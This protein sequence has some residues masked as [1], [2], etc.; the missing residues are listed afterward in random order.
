MVVLDMFQNI[1]AHDRCERSRW[2]WQRLS[3]SAHGDTFCK[4][5]GGDDGASLVDE[6]L[7][8]SPRCDV[9]AQP[10]RYRSPLEGQRH[11]PLALHGT[12][13]GTDFVPEQVARTDERPEAQPPP[14]ANGA[15]DGL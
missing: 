14:R 8:A 2:K 3:V 1:A 9:Q 11:Q 10:G 13:A 4:Q 7:Q 12:T 5:V 15:F 6:P